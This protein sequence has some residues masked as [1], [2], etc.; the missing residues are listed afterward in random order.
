[1]L[2][3][4]LSEGTMD[5]LVKDGLVIVNL[6]LVLESSGTVG[7]AAAVG[8]AP[9]VGEGEVFIHDVIFHVAPV[10]TAAAVLLDLFG[11]GVDV[12]ALGKETRQ[13]FLGGGSAFG[14][15]LVVTV[16]GLVRASHF[17]GRMN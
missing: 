1:M 3:V 4:L 2:L 15:A 7:K 14:D 6:E 16:V 10:T 11:I 9:G 12:A 13:V 17:E 8:A 5:G